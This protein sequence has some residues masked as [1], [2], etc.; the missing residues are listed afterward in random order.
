MAGKEEAPPDEGVT[1]TVMTGGAA[2]AEEGN[3]NPY[4]DA[5]AGLLSRTISDV[6]PAL[7]ATAKGGDE[8]AA[9]AAATRQVETTTTRKEVI[10]LQKTKTHYVDHIRTIIYPRARKKALAPLSGPPPPPPP[11]PPFFT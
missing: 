10:F 8:G 2:E 9:S 4:R 11:P 3:A 1:V 6:K 5:R 7:R